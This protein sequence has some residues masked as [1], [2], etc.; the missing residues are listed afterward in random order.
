[1]RRGPRLRAVAGLGAGTASPRFAIGVPGKSANGQLNIALIGSG[2]WIAQQP[3]NQGRSEEKLV[4]FCDGDRDKCAENM[5]TWR[6]TQPFF[7]DVR[8]MLDKLHK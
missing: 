7:D 4:P 2:V 8:A 3:Y 5:K 6:T 1:M